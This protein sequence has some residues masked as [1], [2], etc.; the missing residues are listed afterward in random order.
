MATSTSIV[1]RMK[2]NSSGKFP[3]MIRITKD[4]KTSYMS[5]GYYIDLKDW[6]TKK[7]KVKKSYPNSTRLNNFLIQK[8]SEVTSKVL[9]LQ[10][11][12]NGL[13]LTKIKNSIKKPSEKR[14]FNSLSK[15]YIN[16]LIT[17]NKLS[18]LDADQPRI[19]NFIAFAGTKN[20]SFQD[21]DEAFLKRFMTYLKVERKNSERSV[22]NNLVIIRTLFNRA[23]R[24]G[25][26][27]QKFYP[28][29]RGKIKIKFPESIKIGLSV[30]EVKK[31]EALTGLTEN[32]NHARNVW[33]FSLYNAGMRVGDLLNI[34]WSDIIDERISYKMS[35]N[36]KSLS[37]NVRDKVQ[38]ILEQYEKDKQN[39]TDFIFP[40]L[41]KANLKSPEDLLRKKK[42]ANKKF[43][44]YLKKVSEKAKIDK[45][46]TMHIARH[47][48]GN[49][50]GEQIPI[51]M[52][53]KLYRHSSITTTINYQ[54]N[55]MHEEVDSAIDKV[56]NF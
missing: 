7:R 50:S 2:A 18:R 8:L 10:S 35:K 53:Q 24:E 29:G 27:N 33:L 16:E 9:E 22:V 36:S 25:I 12:E 40:E 54:A 1:L 30:E 21:I 26:I 11:N 6:D 52:L 4:R 3:L 23:I 5:S 14:T 49:I 31:I 55:F 48:F 38:G 41:K 42:S 28:F 37:F 20:L 43:N 44:K 46:I 17:N 19:K 39:N 45:K 32:E 13:S 15:E 47:T 56:F 34:K 51:Q